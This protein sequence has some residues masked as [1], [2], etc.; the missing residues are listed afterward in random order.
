M[1]TR[2][3]VASDVTAP[4]SNLKNA[5]TIAGHF[6]WGK[7]ITSKEGG[8]AINNKSPEIPLINSSLEQFKVRFPRTRERQ[9]FITPKKIFP[10][11]R[12]VT[13]L[14]D[15]SSRGE[16]EFTNIGPQ[17]T[18]F[19]SNVFLQSLTDEDFCLHK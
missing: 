6:L 10:T 12:S 7:M 8:D 17:V 16:I 1:A 11:R 2:L 14:S 3:S 18:D 9:K 4:F 15:S 19:I 13:R 5:F